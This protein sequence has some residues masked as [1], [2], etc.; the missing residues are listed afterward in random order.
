MTNAPSIVRPST[1]GG[2]PSHCQAIARPPC[3]GRGRIR[4]RA[5]TRRGW[6]WVW[7]KGRDSAKDG[8]LGFVHVHRSSSEVRVTKRGG[9]SWFDPRISSFTTKAR[10]HTNSPP[11]SD[12]IFEPSQRCGQPA[13]QQG[14]RMPLRILSKP[15]VMRRFLVSSFLADVT[16]QIHSLRASGVMSAHTSFTTGSDSIARRKSAGTRCTA[17]VRA[18]LLVMFPVPLSRDSVSKRLH[19]RK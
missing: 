10:A 1:G 2:E 13:Q 3:R 18:S 11:R 16:Q 4:L 8:A 17:P 5:L 14:R 19:A 9:A 7:E 12:D 6:T 15:T